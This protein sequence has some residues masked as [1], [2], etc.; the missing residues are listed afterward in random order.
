MRTGGKKT[1]NQGS[2]TLVLGLSSAGIAVHPDRI[3]RQL[4]KGGKKKR[5]KKKKPSKKD[6]HG[7]KRH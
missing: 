5:R 7:K 2:F 1:D 4:Q 6:F 3:S